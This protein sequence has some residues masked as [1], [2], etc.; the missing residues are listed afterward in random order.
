[1]VLAATQVI[2]LLEQI[3]LDVNQK[4]YETSGFAEPEVFT[5]TFLKSLTLQHRSSAS[6]RAYRLMSPIQL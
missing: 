5:V 6:S 2:K 4:M 3:V 1:M